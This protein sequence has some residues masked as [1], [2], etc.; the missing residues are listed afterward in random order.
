MLYCLILILVLSMTRYKSIKLTEKDN[1]KIETNTGDIDSKLNNI[2]AKLDNI[3][4][5]LTKSNQQIQ[6][7]DLNEEIIPVQNSQ[8]RILY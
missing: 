1:K 5:I 4:N 7:S 8:I 6:D 2:N 3:E